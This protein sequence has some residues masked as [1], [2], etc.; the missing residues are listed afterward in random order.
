M[1]LG[2]GR[3]TGTTIAIPVPQSLYEIPRV[4][5]QHLPTGDPVRRITAIQEQQIF[6]AVPHMAVAVWE[7][8]SIKGFL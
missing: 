8:G 1:R 4:P 5:E 3:R 2:D 7:Q 6:S